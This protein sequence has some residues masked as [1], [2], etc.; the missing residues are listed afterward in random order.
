MKGGN[1]R[2]SASDGEVGGGQEKPAP[3]G[4][5]PQAPPDPGQEVLAAKG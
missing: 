2:G 4:P 1:G 3:A 5:S